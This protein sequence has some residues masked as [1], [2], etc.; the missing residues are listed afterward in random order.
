MSAYGIDI[1]G[2]FRIMNSHNGPASSHAIQ[3]TSECS[4]VTEASSNL[5]E[6]DRMLE[7]REVDHEEQQVPLAEVAL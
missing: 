4:K 3:R 6:D 1:D 7:G 5:L 2:C